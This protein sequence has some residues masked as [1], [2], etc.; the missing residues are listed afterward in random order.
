M[1]LLYT[2]LD[3]IVQIKALFADFWLQTYHLE[4]VKLLP[5]QK[6]SV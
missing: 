4:A 3:T 5:M 2:L 6:Q 1:M